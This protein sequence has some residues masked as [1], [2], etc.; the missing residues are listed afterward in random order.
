MFSFS[1]GT[2]GCITRR[3]E[4][5]LNCFK[6]KVERVSL[7][8]SIEAFVYDYLIVAQLNDERL[9][10]GIASLTYTIRASLDEQIRN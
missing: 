5:N 6:G 10:S 7:T 3:N 8:R 1:R 4:K 2:R 9:R